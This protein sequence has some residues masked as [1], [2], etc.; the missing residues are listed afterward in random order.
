[1]P[2]NP[3]PRRAFS[4]EFSRWVQANPYPD[5]H[6]LIAKYGAYWDIPEPEWQ[7]YRA[8][9]KDWEQRRNERNFG[10]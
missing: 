8:A 6:A 2:R 3:P 7:E 4:V 1:M 10:P 9:V 5:L